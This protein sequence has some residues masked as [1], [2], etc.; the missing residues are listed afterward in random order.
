MLSKAGRRIILIPLI[1][2]AEKDVYVQ[3]KDR[4]RRERENER[5]RDR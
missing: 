1:S 3:T 4:E 5:E 2:S